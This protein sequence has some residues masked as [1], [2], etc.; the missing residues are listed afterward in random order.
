MFLLDIVSVSPIEIAADMVSVLFPFILAA[1]VIIGAAI[2]IIKAV[3]K[4]K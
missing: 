2:L 3:K 4:K 1:A